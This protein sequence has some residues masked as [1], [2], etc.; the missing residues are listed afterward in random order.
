MRVSHVEHGSNASDTRRF[1]YLL[2][3]HKDRQD[4]YQMSHPY[5]TDSGSE[6][7]EPTEP[8]EGIG[9]NFESRVE[10]ANGKQRIRRKEVS[11]TGDIIGATPVQKFIIPGEVER[12]KYHF[13][14]VEADGIN[15]EQANTLKARCRRRD[16]PS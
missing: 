15:T 10:W 3:E 7:I 8:A 9:H 13:D 1:R 5:H 2:T 14:K 12:T 6:S 16:D 11:A 4:H